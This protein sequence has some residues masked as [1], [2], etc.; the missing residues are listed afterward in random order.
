[1]HLAA[2]AIVCSARLHGETGVIARVL[3][4]EHGLLAGYV[5]G[6]RGRDLRPVLIPGNAVD[7]EIRARPGSQL[8][9]FRVELIASRGPWLGEPLPA[10]AIGWITAITAAALPERHAYP[11]LHA[12][13]GGLLDAVCHAPS[14]RGWVPGLLAYEALL[15]RELGYGEPPWRAVLAQDDS[16]PALLALFDRMGRALARYPLADR[17]GDV[18]GARALLR[19]RLARIGGADGTA[20]Q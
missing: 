8:P 19:E 9:G 10:A 1:M 11:P 13:L 14:A 4:T 12:A 16:W 15:L 5:A 3:T 17:R 2:P 6:G 18:M 7:V 20:P